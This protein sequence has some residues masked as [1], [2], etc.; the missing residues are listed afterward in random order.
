MRNLGKANSLSKL[1]K[2]GF[3]VPRF[4]VC[5]SSCPEKKILSKIEAELSS[6]KFFAVRSSAAN[7]DSKLKSYAG[8]FYSGIGVTNEA[9]FTEVKKVHESFGQI[10]GKVII[11]DFIPSESAGVMFTEVEDNNIV[12]NSTIGLCQPVVSGLAC[13]EY[14]CNKNGDILSKTIS[15]KKEIRLFI[16]NKI[17]KQISDVES[18]TEKQIKQLIQLGKRIQNF[19]GSKQDVEWCFL[20]NKLYVLQSR[21][22]TRDFTI[23]K[24]RVYF[25]SANIAESYS[26]IVLPLTQSFARVV[27]AQVY[28]DLLRMSG[29]FVKKLDHH[30][31]IFENLLGFFYGRMYYN[32]NNWYLMAA[33]IPGYKRNKENFELMITSNIKQNITTSIKPSLIFSFIYPLIVIVKAGIYGFTS[34]YFKN[35]VTKELR[36]LQD[37]NFDQLQ[38][39]DCIDL[40]EVINMKLL[41][42]WYIAV[43]NDFF[44]MTYLG[45]LKKLINEQLLQKVIK[46]PSKSTEQVTELSLLSKKMYEV[47]NLWN[48]IEANDVKRFNNELPHHRELERL[49]NKYLHS[50]GGR[51]ANELKLESVGVDEDTTKLFSVL[52]AYR[53]Y[54]LKLNVLSEEIKL[55][56]FK[57]IIVQII[58]SKFKKHASLREEFRLLRSNTF[59]MARR[60]F[61]RMGVILTENGV[62]ENAD[63]IFYLQMEELLDQ[64]ALKNKQCFSSS[65]NLAKIIQQRKKDYN[66][67]K[68]ITP[69]SHF[70]TTNNL[71]PSVKQDIKFEGNIIHASPASPGIIKGRVRVFKEFSMPEKIDFDILVT[72]HTDPGWT[73]LI[74]LSKGLIIEHGGVLSHASIVA[75]ELNIPAVIGARDAMVV[76]KNQQMVEIDG[77]TG[78]IRII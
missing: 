18:L 40:F 49:L 9:V 1:G 64:T 37:Q 36:K 12:I 74:A 31:E 65:K 13:D 28:R 47:K 68:S 45:I 26:G 14:I 30:P 48:A 10:A 69:P 52:K 16:N 72:S 27:Y 59:C 4:F 3:L 66:S 15:K 78:T 71:P 44:V 51:F 2:A 55:P 58:L 32:M 17:I 34:K 33:F 63:D 5:N 61:R 60:L 11:Q 75:R 38:Y 25:D 7:E 50:F 67:Y 19:F 35:T 56:F 21:P 22:I 29:V 62:I 57:K 20:N 42:Q 77:S 23:F 43:E 41:R 39:L 54:K 46:F 70:A 8:H 76:L 6:V 53:N 73:S 24:D